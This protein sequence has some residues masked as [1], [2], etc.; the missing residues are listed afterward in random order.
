MSVPAAVGSASG[1]RNFYLL[2][3]QQMV[4]A[5]P[6]SPTRAKQDSWGMQGST[7]QRTRM[8]ERQQNQNAPHGHPNKDGCNAACPVHHRLHPPKGCRLLTKGVQ[9]C[10]HRPSHVIC[11]VHDTMRLVTVS[12][13]D[14]SV[15][16]MYT[17]LTIGPLT[18]A[19]E[20]ECNIQC[21]H[22]LYDLRHCTWPAA[23]EPLACSQQS[24]CHGGWDDTQPTDNMTPTNNR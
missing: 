1:C 3:I 16:M 17:P 9:G 20:S 5:W 15:A 12:G 7:I 6:D 21:T 4:R 24:C 11:M 18:V 10:S 14:A 23:H 19:L 13:W 2:T 22:F 8:R